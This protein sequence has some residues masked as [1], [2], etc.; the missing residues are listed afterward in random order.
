MKLS[1]EEKDL[2]SRMSAEDQEIMCEM[3]SVFREMNPKEKS[4]LLNKLERDIRITDLLDDE[5]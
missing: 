3:L 4:E 1:K 5:N 2:M